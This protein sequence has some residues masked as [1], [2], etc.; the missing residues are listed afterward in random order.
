MR[1][2]RL[3]IYVRPMG[4]RFILAWVPALP[5][6]PRRVATAEFEP[7]QPSRWSAANP[8]LPLRRLRCD[9]TS[10]YYLDPS[11]SNF[12]LSQVHLYILSDLR[13]WAGF[14]HFLLG[15]PRS[16]KYG[17]FSSRLMVS[18]AA[19]P[20]RRIS[21]LPANQDGEVGLTYPHLAPL[22]SLEWF[23]H[24][25]VRDIEGRP[26]YRLGRNPSRTSRFTHRARHAPGL[27][28]RPLAFANQ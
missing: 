5:E 8:D 12:R 4:A 1:L 14:L 9:W 18:S 26:A 27:A 20:P 17:L 25:P 6:A 21:V 22:V 23:V 28:T 3:R 16:R 11:T 13:A 24:R 15:R 19:T 2:G 10:A 7:V